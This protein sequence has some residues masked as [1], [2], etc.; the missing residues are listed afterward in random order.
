[1]QLSIY[2]LYGYSIFLLAGG[3][4][5]YLLAGSLISIYLSTGFTLALLGCTE[6][7]RRQHILARSI[8]LWLISSLFFFFSWRYLKTGSLFPA[9]LMALISMNVWIGLILIRRRSI[10]STSRS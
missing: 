9:G 3:M 7:M 10:P 6:G 2:I 8:A 4:T 1:M 5:G